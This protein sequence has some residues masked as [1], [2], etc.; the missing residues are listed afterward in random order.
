MFLEQVETTEVGA[1]QRRTAYR[2]FE[3]EVERVRVIDW[4]IESSSRGYP[5]DLVG[6][7]SG[8]QIVWS[9]GGLEEDATLQLKSSTRELVPD[10]RLAEGD[11]RWW[12]RDNSVTERECQ[13]SLRERM[14]EHKNICCLLRTICDVEQRQGTKRLLFVV[15]DRPHCHH[16]TWRKEARL[17]RLPDEDRQ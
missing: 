15:A 2:V 4:L 10:A 7:M 9:R 13:E 5:S 16:V 14:T 3:A 8:T 1:C 6:A 12:G 11:D 17:W